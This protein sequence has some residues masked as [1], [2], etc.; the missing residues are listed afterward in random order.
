ML[1]EKFACFEVCTEKKSAAPIFTLLGDTSRYFFVPKERGHI[2]NHMA[3]I[4]DIPVA[5]IKRFKHLK[6][7]IENLTEQGMSEQAR[8]VAG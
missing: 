2:K 3:D 7:V 1:K 6:P 5:Q 8:R 4:R